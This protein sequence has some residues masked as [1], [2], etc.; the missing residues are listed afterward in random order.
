MTPEPG[1]SSLLTVHI[2]KINGAVAGFYL[3]SNRVGSFSLA[4]GLVKLATPTEVTHSA[5]SSA[6]SAAEATFQVRWNAPPTRGGVVFDVAAV[7][8]NG[9]N[10]P[11]GDS[12]AY[13][14]FSMTAGCPGIMAFV[15]LDGDGF[16]R[17]SD[18]VRVCEIGPG[19]S[20]K[21]GDCDDGNP[22]SY[23]GNAE[24]CNYYD[25]N[26]DGKVNEGL[27]SVIMYRD[28]DGDGHGARDTTDTRM[29]CTGVSGYAAV[30]DDCND[31]DKNTYPGAPEMCDGIDNNCNAKIDDGARA[32]CGVGWCRRL[33]PT[34]DPASCTQG[35]PRAEQCNNFDD[36]CDGVNDNGVDL[37]GGGKIC[38][39]GYCLLPSEVDGGFVDP[40][41]LA[42]SGGSASAPIPGIDGGVAQKAQAS[43]RG[44][45]VGAPRSAARHGSW[46][47]VLLV[48][49]ASLRRCRRSRR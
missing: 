37:C 49:T 10:D 3:S 27:E 41:A 11:G 48:L 19:V 31:N 24:V 8:A 14:R 18:Q 32:S 25:D 2:S 6:G 17:E 43:A 28:A 13:G 46:P 45:A 35:Q 40:S 34:C 36:D 23:P 4:G 20:A 33:A 30:A 15:D 5:P 44:C 38:S 21:A 16:G 7:S 9:N 22:A 47:L 1:T 42:G 29:G 26:C 39:R 12:A